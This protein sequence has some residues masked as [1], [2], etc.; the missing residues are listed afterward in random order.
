MRPISTLAWKRPQGPPASAPSTI[1]SPSIWA[2][3]E[4][5]L[6]GIARAASHDAV[7]V[8]RWSPSSTRAAGV[9]VSYVGHPLADVFPLAPNREAMREMLQIS[10]AGPVFAL[11]PGSRQS[12]VRRPAPTPYIATAALLHE[13]HPGARFLVPLATR[14][15]RLLFEDGPVAVKPTWTCRSASSSATPARQ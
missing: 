11:L 6:K 15:T 1:V 8:S 13:R 9:P 12:E 4:G 2:W 5:R 7:P 10:P 14:E 3:R